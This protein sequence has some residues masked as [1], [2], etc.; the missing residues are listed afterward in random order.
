MLYMW[1]CAVMKKLLIKTNFLVNWINLLA[2]GSYFYRVVS[3]P[4]TQEILSYIK[5]FC[6]YC[7]NRCISFYLLSRPMR[8]V[9]I[10]PFFFACNNMINKRLIYVSFKEIINCQLSRTY[11]ESL[12]LQGSLS[13]EWFILI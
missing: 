9:W 5:T 10:N 3:W 1:S 4:Y 8:I 11:S 13:K 6:E 2:V 7:S 12:N